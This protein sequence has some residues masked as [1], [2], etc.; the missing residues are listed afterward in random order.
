[1]DVEILA[2]GD[3]LLLGLTR[4]ANATGFLSKSPTQV[5]LCAG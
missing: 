3:E 1:M 2:I 5:A 4:D